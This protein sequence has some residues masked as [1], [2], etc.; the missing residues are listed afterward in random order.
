MINVALPAEL[1]ALIENKLKSEHYASP[2]EVIR[3]A[4]RLLDQRDEMLA[5]WSDEIREQ[6]SAGWKSAKGGDLVDGEEVFNRVEVEL[7]AVDR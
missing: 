7:D 1:E 6:I 2:A 4:L 3:E 5:T